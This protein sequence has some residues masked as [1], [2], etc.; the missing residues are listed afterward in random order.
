MFTAHAEEETAQKFEK[1]TSDVDQVLKA[2][3]VKLKEYRDKN[4]PRPHLDDKIL[5]SWNGLMVALSK[6]ESRDLADKFVIR[7]P[8]WPRRR[9]AMIP[10]LSTPRSRFG[11][12]RA[13]R[14]SSVGTC[15]TRVLGS[16][17][18]VTAKDQVPSVRRMTMLS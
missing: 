4:R 15:M 1:H 11:L 12:L 13:R 5:T 9:N 18:G 7:S 10:R 8:G 2:C 6:V 17:E 16:C 3:L 14:I